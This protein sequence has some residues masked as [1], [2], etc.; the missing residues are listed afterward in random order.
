MPCGTMILASEIDDTVS[1]ILEWKIERV[2][3]RNCIRIDHVPRPQ[4][5]LERILRS[6]DGL[7]P[8]LLFENQRQSLVM[9]RELTKEVL[10]LPS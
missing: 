7:I 1:D 4:G 9:V 5:A 8:A 6:G 2:V 10:Y 3:H